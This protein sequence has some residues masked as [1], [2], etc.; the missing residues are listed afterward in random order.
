MCEY[1]KLKGVFGW[2]IAHDGMITCLDSRDN[3]L[4]SGGID[5]KISIWDA[6]MMSRPMKKISPDDRVILKVG[7]GPSSLLAVS[8]LNGLYL[9]N[10]DT[11]DYSKSIGFAD[12]QTGR[13][14]DMAWCYEDSLLYVAG[15]DS[16]IDSYKLVH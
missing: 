13:Y 9:V 3:T 11:G 8:T 5:S 1:L 6:R 16:T 4:V 10:S 2:P 14:N 12:K 15:E 7:I